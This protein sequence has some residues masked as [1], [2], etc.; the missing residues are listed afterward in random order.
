MTRL[1][2]MTIAGLGW[3]ILGAGCAKK[4]DPQRSPT[5][6]RGRALF[7]S[8][9][10]ANCHGLEGDGSQNA[11]PLRGAESRFSATQLGTYLRDPSAF[12]KNDTR[13]MQQQAQYGALMPR[14]NHLEDRDLAALVEYVLTM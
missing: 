6:E 4:A 3:L 2:F 9:R 13:L 11:P 7:I 10:C 12:I 5:L 14:F 1:L 8:Q